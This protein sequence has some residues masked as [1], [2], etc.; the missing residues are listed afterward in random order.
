MKKLR[1]LLGL[2]LVAAALLMMSACGGDGDDD[3]S[4]SSTTPEDSD[5]A[6]DSTG[7][8]DTEVKWG[9]HFPL[10]GNPAAA[11][12]PIAF[13]MDA[14]FK[15]INAQGGIYGRQLTLLIGDDHYNPADTV[16]VVRKLVEQDQVFGIIGG[17]GE[18]T[19]LS[20]YKYLEERGIPDM[21]VS[22]GLL[23]WVEPVAKNR[24]GG[25]PDYVVEGTFL[26]QYIANNFDGKKLGLLIQNDALGAEGETGLKK[27]IEG[28]DVEIVATESYEAE[29]PDVSSQTQRL[30]DAGAEVVAVFAIPPQAAS[31]VKTARETLN[32]DIPIIVSGI[33]SSDIFVLLAGAETAEGVVSFTFGHQAYEKDFPGI[34]TYDKIWAKY[35]NG[36]DLNNFETY[37]MFVAELTIH[38][39]ELAGP[40][41]TRE[42]FL[43]AAESVC[44]F[45]C[46]SCPGVGPISLSPTDHKPTEALIYNEVQDGK[47][48]AISD[49]V[50]VESTTDCSPP[51][52]P[53]GYADQ[54]PVGADAQFVDIP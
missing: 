1:L 25:N 4:A 53:E 8:T 38:I 30:R 44:Q 50:A 16:E 47:W 40:D 27:G 7:V 43:D 23:K 2:G 28:S 17:L 37:G 9:T 21:F 26:G 48:V 3:E 54:P 49:P 35:G 52:L 32:W 33:N 14:F 11:Y 20:V 13:G 51:E 10:S 34:Q 29:Q 39:M 41:L 15:Y 5:V 12:A 46:T 18:A 6:G 36:G 42:S 31:L 45:W 24:F 19:H 22:T